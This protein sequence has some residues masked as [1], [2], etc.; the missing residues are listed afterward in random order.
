MRGQRVI[1]E[2]VASD[3][4][5]EDFIP[6]FRA[7]KVGNSRR[8][9]RLEQIYWTTLNE[10]ASQKGMGLGQ[11]VE[12]VAR[13]FP[14]AVNITSV[15]RVNATGWLHD[16]YDEARRHTGLA[17]IDSLVQACPSP[18]FA[19]QEDK[20]IVA[21]NQSFISY[22]QARFSRFSPASMAKGLRLSLDVQ[23]GEL[24]E[25]LKKADCKPVRTGFVLGID[26]QRLRG[27]LSTT[28]APSPDKMTFLGYVAP[29]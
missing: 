1:G 9:I 18:A 17:V 29:M 2:S 16:R 10:I 11:Y 15:L 23:I 21:Y 8:G 20:R 4:R 13:S 19:L 25:M 6:K 24:A 12:G 14:E 28:L 5:D 22:I 3:A 27:Q 7:V 26:D